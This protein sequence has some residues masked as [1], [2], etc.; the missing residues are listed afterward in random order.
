MSGINGGDLVGFVTGTIS[1]IEVDGIVVIVM[2]SVFSEFRWA[3]VILPLAS[4][5]LK[6]LCR[7][8]A[9][10]FLSPAKKLAGT[11]PSRPSNS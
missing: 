3:F 11:W 1:G 4:S 8:I 5:I 6:T 2:S 7:K 9:S 10:N